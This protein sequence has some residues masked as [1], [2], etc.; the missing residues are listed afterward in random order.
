MAN[1]LQDKLR[2]LSGLAYY[3]KSIESNPNQT[4]NTKRR[5]ARM[6]S[7]VEPVGRSPI[8]RVSPSVGNLANS[9]TEDE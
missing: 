2:W 5:T 9:T 3:R 1:S 7:F 6:K 4:P 8:R